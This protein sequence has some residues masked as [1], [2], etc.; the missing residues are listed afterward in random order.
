MKALINK[1]IKTYSLLMLG[2]L[3]IITLYTYLC[4]RF[5]SIK[6]ILG[7]TVIMLPSIVGIVVFLGDHSLQH[8]ILSLPVSRK[9][10]VLSK[11]ISTLLFGF[12]LIGISILILYFL[13]LQY[14]DAKYELERLSSWIGLIFC[15]TPIVLIISVCYPLLF[16]FGLK[17]GVRIVMGSFALL[18]GLGMVVA[19]K[20]IQSNF[21]VPGGG[22]F[23]AVIGIFN[24]Y[25][26][27][28]TGFFLII[29]LILA[30]ILSLSMI[31]SI[32]AL[33]QKDIV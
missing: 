22:I 7:F 33:K 13:S 8:L 12:T 23:N 28:G 14:T 1:D 17:V 9:T 3:V 32:H 18:Y 20:W 24:H 26:Q 30:A 25:D 2:M 16:K 5:D 11:Y 19:E 27:L 10:F 4:V 15:M 31:A 6:G 29:L 21:L